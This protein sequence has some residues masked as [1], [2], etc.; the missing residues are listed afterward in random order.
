MAFF[1][2]LQQAY[3]CRDTG[4]YDE[5]N[6]FARTRS[7]ARALEMGERSG[8]GTMVNIN[9]GHW[10]AIALDFKQSLVWY[11]DSFGNPA[12][13]SVVLVINWWTFHHTGQ[14]FAYQK[15]KISSQTDGFSCG[16][17]GTNGLG[18][19]YMSE[20]THLLMWH[21]LMWSGLGYYSGWSNAICIRLM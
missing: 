19:F 6:H 15:M 21:G 2:T 9:G 11:G 3:D 20:S 1:A 18:H 4:E 7:I 5:S 14:V 13:K 8:L 12:I 17:L 10:V 16:L